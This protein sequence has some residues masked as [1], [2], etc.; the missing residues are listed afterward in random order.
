MSCCTSSW[1]G[2]SSFGPLSDISILCQVFE[3]KLWPI[4]G[5]KVGLSDLNGPVPY[6]E[7]EVADQLSKVYHKV[8]AD[9]EVHWRDSLKPC[10]PS[11]IFPLPPQLQYLHPEIERLATTR[12][13]WQQQPQ[14]SQRLL[15][16]G[17]Q[18]ALQMDHTPD[19]PH[20]DEAFE[21]NLPDLATPLQ[22][23]GTGFPSTIPLLPG[24]NVSS[25]QVVTA[26]EKIRGAIGR[27]HKKR[28]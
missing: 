2:P 22:P 13:L 20:Q 6:S 10:D 14:Q 24:L 25:E 23:G 3:K 19:S 21:Q 11:A 28:T 15:G 1:V 18:Q 17:L 9:F 8:L 27:F 16:A 26:M 7:P 12:F 4:I 5:A